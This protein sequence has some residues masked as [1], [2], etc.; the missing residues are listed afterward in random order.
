M[1]GLQRKRRTLAE[2]LPDIFGYQNFSSL[3]DVLPEFEGDVYRFAKTVMSGNQQEFP[4]I[5]S[6]AY[7]KER[8]ARWVLLRKIDGVIDCYRRC[9][10]MCGLRERRKNIVRQFSHHFTLEVLDQR[11]HMPLHP[12]DLAKVRKNTGTPD[13][14]RIPAHVEREH[15]ALVFESIMNPTLLRVPLGC[16]TGHELVNQR[17]E[18]VHRGLAE[19]SRNTA[20]I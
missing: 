10:G 2:S 19:M 14:E 11:P 15:S 3:R 20:S 17:E 8:F 5:N 6:N 13:G 1:H 16:R 18:R 9:N 12:S 4:I 7:R